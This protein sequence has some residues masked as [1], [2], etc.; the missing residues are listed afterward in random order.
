MTDTTDTKNRAG[1]RINAAD[2][3]AAQVVPTAR[4]LR[5]LTPLGMGE[6][7]ITGGFWKDRQEVN[8]S[9]TIPHCLDWEERIGWIDNFARAADGT[10][11][12]HHA[13]LWFAD[14]DVYK[15]IE[16]MAWEVGRSGD[17]ALEA[18][19]QRL[20]ALIEAVQDDDGYLNTRYGKPGTEERYSD[21]PMGHELY[22]TGHLI[23]AAVA[24]LR[25]GRTSD[26]V[27]VRIALRN[28]DHVCER[29]GRDG[30]AAVGGHPGGRNRPGRALPRHRPAPL[31]GA[32]PALPRPPRARPAR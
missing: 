3:P 21:F 28:A 7:I 1:G 25:T 19:I 31:P 14:S 20:G 6:V 8:A 2:A 10:I 23:Q 27:I 24:R 4:A 32:G 12:G 9:A 15:L 29:F 22:C 18:Q 17:P 16:S 11:A 5:A 30:E 13:G 26:D